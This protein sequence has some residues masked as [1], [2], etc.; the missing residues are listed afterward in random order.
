MKAP[1]DDLDHLRNLLSSII[2]LAVHDACTS[3][4]KASERGR[5]QRPTDHAIDAI[6]FLFNQDNRSYFTKYAEC[7]DMEAD[8]F[9][10]KLLRTMYAEDSLDH[11][12][13]GGL[14]KS[15]QKSFRF[16]HSYWL[17]QESPQKGE[18]NAVIQQNRR[19]LDPGILAS[20]NA[21]FATGDGD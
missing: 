17:T 9:R 13:Y 8:A 21:S 18:L 14:P 6:R 4:I 1:K 10:S 19:H 5:G 3:P 15:A 11:L 2:W 12:P 16:N 20:L 7:L